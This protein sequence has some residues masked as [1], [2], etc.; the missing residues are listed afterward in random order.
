MTGHRSTLIIDFGGVLTTDLWESVRACA[1]RE[2]L[3]DD[4]LLNLLRNDLHQLFAA[5]ERGEVSQAY[6]EQQLAAAAGLS[7]ERLLG[8]MCADIRP[9]EVMLAAVDT[10]RRTG[11]KVGILSHPWGT[12][13]GVD[14]YFDP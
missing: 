12:G 5:L 8:R 13:P 9:D 6:F 4:A 1:R 3:P 7:P 10:L 11:V 14:A 2:G